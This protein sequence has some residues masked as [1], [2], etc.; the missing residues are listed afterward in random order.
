MFPVIVGLVHFNAVK[1]VAASTPTV[2]PVSGSGT[3]SYISVPFSVQQ[4]YLKSKAVS[5][6]GSSTNIPGIIEQGEIDGSFVRLLAQSVEEEGLYII[7]V[8]V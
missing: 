6:L 3:G 5:K 7:R 8:Q 1:H 4:K 2:L